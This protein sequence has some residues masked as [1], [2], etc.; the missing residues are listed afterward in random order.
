SENSAS[1]NAPMVYSQALYEFSG[2][3][4]LLQSVLSQFVNGLLPQIESMRAFLCAGDLKN[5]EMIAHK[6]CGGAGNLTAYPMSEK[7]SKLER[8]CKEGAR[9]ESLV[10]LE[11]LGEEFARLRAFVADIG[12]TFKK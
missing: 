1:S 12:Q 6:I 3:Q 7:A 4:Q 11:Q 2:N 10:L 8:K 5:A 9:E